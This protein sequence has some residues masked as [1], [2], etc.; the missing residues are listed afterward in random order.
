MRSRFV[1]PALLGALV[2]ALALLVTPWSSSGSRSLAAPSSGYHLIKKVTLGGEG[3][4]DYLKFDDDANRLFISRGTHVMVVD[5]STYAVVGDIPDTDGVHGIALAPEFGRGFTSD[6]RSNQVTIF[7]LKTLK[8]IGTAKTGEGADGI[9]YDPGSKRVFTFNGRAGTSTAIDA[10]NGQVAGT[11]TLDG[12][13]E[14]G[15]ADGEGHVYNNLED[16]SIVL[17]IDS[18]N[19]KVLNRWPLAP[20]ES[21]SGMAIDPEHRRLFIGCHNKLMAIMDADNGKVVATVPIGQGVD[22]NR[23]DPG[24]QLAFSSNGDGTLTVVHEDSPDKYTVVDNVET[25]R[26]ARTMALD[27]KTHRVFSVTAEFE[28]PPADAKPGER[29]RPSMVP[30]TFTLLVL[31]Q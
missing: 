11:I 10:E 9:I 14:F 21:P 5:G 6:G 29:R 28:P 2:A 22:A 25:Q 15:A 3:F 16:K 4:W 23:F 24:T 31:G 26:G 12:R 7:D 13:P 27:L 18:K 20:C 8:T 19:L 30:G 17:Q 1:S